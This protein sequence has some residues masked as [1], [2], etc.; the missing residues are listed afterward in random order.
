MALQA[1]MEEAERLQK[2]TQEQ[3]S[4][5]STLVSRNIT[6]LGRRT[7]VRLE[8]EMWTALR[9]IAQREGCRI[10]DLCS[11]IQI[12]KNPQTSLT[13]AIRVFLML[14]FRASSTEEGHRRC[15]HGSFDNMLTRA[16][17][18]IEQ[19][20]KPVDGV[21][22]NRTGAAFVPAMVVSHGASATPGTGNI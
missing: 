9:D 10:H 5:R 4:G 21:A 3:D 7:S 12:R 19:L 1:L 2:L 8:P 14:Y 15:G 11:L 18:T 17:I 6:V 16:R 20:S 13:A 22:Q